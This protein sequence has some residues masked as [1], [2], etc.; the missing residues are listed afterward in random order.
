MADLDAKMPRCGEAESVT[1]ITESILAPMVGEEAIVHERLVSVTSAGTG[2]GQNEEIQSSPSP[3]FLNSLPF[4]KK[5]YPTPR[6]GDGKVSEIIHENSSNTCHSERQRRNPA[7]YCNTSK[8]QGENMNNL[9]ETNNTPIPNIGGVGTPPYVDKLASDVGI[10]MPTYSSK[11]LAASLPSCLAAKKAAF[12]LAE[13]LITLGIIG[14][15]AALTLPTIIKNYQKKVT[16]ERLKKVYSTLSQAVQMSVKDNDE[17]EGWNFD[18]STKDF[19]NK[20]LIPYIKDIKSEDEKVAENQ[21]AQRYV[22]ADGTA[23][24]AWSWKNSEIKPFFMLYVDINGDK[25]PN[26]YGKDIFVFHIFSQES[27]RYNAGS[28]DVAQNI[29][30]AG[31]YPDGYGYSRDTMLNNGWRGCNK[32]G[33]KVTNSGIETNNEGGAFCT[34][35]IM[36]D[37]WQIKEDYKW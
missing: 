12:T 21:S 28:G 31:L 11:N 1:E 36:Y 7:Y 29:P 8:S 9:T 33:G 32:R 35:L 27:N 17:I 20:Y 26:I 6:W 15:V 24:R 23:I 30:K 16:V 2:E 22:L 34:A 3:E 5:F 25:S 18:L 14:L 10:A 37:G 19:M 13:V 4:I